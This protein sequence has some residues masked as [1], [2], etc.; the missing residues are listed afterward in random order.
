MTDGSMNKSHAYIISSQDAAVREN[1]ALELAQAMVCDRGGAEACGV[2]AQCRRALAGVHPDIIFIDRLTDD[3]GKRRRE[4]YVDQIRGMSADVWVRPQ[5][6]DRKVYII[7]EANLL[8]QAAQ[9]AALKILE[10]PPAYAVFILCVNSAEELLPTVRSRCVEIRESGTVCRAENKEAEELVD[11]AVSGDAAA[12]CEYCWKCET[13]DSEKSAELIESCRAY[14]SEAICRGASSGV[15][16]GE[17][18]R[19]LGVFDIAAEYLRMNVG[20]KHVW[21]YI[22]VSAI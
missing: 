10:E 6:S 16:R 21:G 17:A 8:N 15:S 5:Q 11:T 19:L 13:L 2:C 7:R 20:A 1:T 22:S 4:I 3:K 18:V 9:N 12:L 14:L